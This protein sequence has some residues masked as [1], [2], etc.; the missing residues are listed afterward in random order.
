MNPDH[1]PLEAAQAELERFDRIATE[2]NVGMAAHILRNPLE[3]V[4][5]L[6][7]LSE[8]ECGRLADL[9]L[10]ATDRHD[11]TTTDPIEVF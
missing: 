10:N 4:I 5:E 11:V 9:L 3:V 7:A 8:T 1:T 2:L 6:L